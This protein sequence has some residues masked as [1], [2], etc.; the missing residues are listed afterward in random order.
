MK[1]EY[2]YSL[3]EIL[4]FR[5]SAVNG[6]GKLVAYTRDSFLNYLIE[7]DSIP[8]KYMSNWT[9]QPGHL[10]FNPKKSRVFSASELQRQ[11]S[12]EVV[13]T[14]WAECT[15]RSYEMDDRTLARLV[16]YDDTDKPVI[17]ARPKKINK[18]IVVDPMGGIVI[19]K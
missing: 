12:T 13:L 3:G 11:N 8:E 16:G 1:E 14:D 19:A 17:L 7:S 18:V 15:I 4:A 9:P 10:N 5:D 2:K 6:I